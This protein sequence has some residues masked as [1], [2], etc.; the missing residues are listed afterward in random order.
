MSGWIQLKNLEKNMAQELHI[1][2]RGVQEI[3]KNIDL[4][5]RL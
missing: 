3:E 2:F 5:V 4:I 1:K